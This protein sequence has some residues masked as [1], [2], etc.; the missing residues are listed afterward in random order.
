MTSRAKARFDGES[1][2]RMSSELVD[3]RDSDAGAER[4]RVNHGS[5]RRP[6][7]V[8]WDGTVALFD[9]GQHCDPDTL[10]VAVIDSTPDR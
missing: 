7:H 6:R 9:H 2:S 5:E 4:L 3:N 8:A 1:R 10:V